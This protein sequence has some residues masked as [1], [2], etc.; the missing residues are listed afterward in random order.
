MPEFD[1]TTSFLHT[2]CN[3]DLSWKGF[4][5]VLMPTSSQKDQ[6]KER[7]RDTML[8]ALDDAQVV[9]CANSIRLY[10]RIQFTRS[11][12]TLWFLRSEWMTTL[13]TVQGESA[14][15]AKV[16]E[17]NRMFKDVLPDSFQPR[18]SKFGGIA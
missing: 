16:H 1:M 3:N 6:A 17:L 5:A 9:S 15:N 11:V 4:S 13:S 12:H 18:I 7:I 8:K 10:W 14:A 2:A